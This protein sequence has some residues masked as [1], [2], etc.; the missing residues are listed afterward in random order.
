MIS[1]II[2]A[3][4]AEAY[5]DRCINSLLRQ[6]ITRIEIIIVNDGSTDAT[7]A[8]AKKFQEKYSVVQVID[9]TNSGLAAARN[10]GLKVAKGDWIAFV[11]A[12][13]ELCDGALEKLQ[14]LATDDVDSVISSIGVYY[15]SP[16]INRLDESWYIMKWKG[17]KHIYPTE[18]F[19]FHCSASAKLFRKSVID[20]IGLKFPEGFWYE[21]WFWHFAFYLLAPNAACLPEITYKYYRHSESFTTNESNRV[22]NYSLQHLEITKQIIAF[23]YDHQLNIEINSVLQR[24]VSESLMFVIR[25]SSLKDQYL[26]CSKCL[27]ILNKEKDLKITDPVLLSILNGRLPIT[28]EIT[29][30]NKKAEVWTLKKKIKAIKKIL[31]Q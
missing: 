18:L 14:L 31:R 28:V 6:N 7:L 29:D 13:D 15:D 11:D 19:N 25:R 5:I 24:L 26:A 8:K 9:Q 2:P 27:D 12:D 21:D 20:K 23:A 3:F 22:V 1:V 17:E 30:A 16:K 4:N 10:A